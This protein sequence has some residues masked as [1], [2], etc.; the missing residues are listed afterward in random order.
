VDGGATRPGPKLR[1]V[2]PALREIGDLK[3]VSSAGRSGSL[4][5]RLFR[6]AWARLVADEEPGAVCAAT[7]A[8]ALAAARLGDLDA[9]A[10]GA[11]GLG[12]GDI[13]AVRRAAY[14][15]LAPSFWLAPTAFLAGLD[16]PPAPEVPLPPFVAALEAQPRAGVTC[17]GKPRL[18][19]PCPENHAEHCLV[20]AVYGALLAS[21][22]A[23]DPTT[24][25]VAALSHHLH[26][27][28][29]P[30]SG[31]TGE[32]L[33][34]DRLL[35][36]FAE[37][38]RQALAQ[39]ADARLRDRVESA[40]RCLPDD[41]TPEGRAFHAADTL[42]RVLQIAWHLQAGR[43]TMRDALVDMELV[44]DGPVKDFQD[45]LLAEAGLLPP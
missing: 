41:R 28:L 31:F 15:Q 26:N 3:R 24:V 11:A 40:R 4:A 32:V 38:T 42:D 21:R 10:L 19:F 14:D 16:A 7:V 5:A 25:F 1:E 30:D 37:A 12:P 29:L 2:V 6:D 35:P 17:P 18:L 20:T 33:L 36:L 9:V 39:L 27:A 8:S 23:A 34:G 43:T 22:Y 45:S 13:A 44:H